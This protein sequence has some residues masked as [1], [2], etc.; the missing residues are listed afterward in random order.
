M[1]G[2]TLLESLIAIAIFAVIGL[3]AVD[4]VN[5][6]LQGNNKA[7]LI[8]KIKQNGQSAL[9]V[10]DETIRSA[11]SIDCVGSL[12]SLTSVISVAKN[13]QHT[14]FRLISQT[15]SSP[16]VNGV[17]I[18][19]NLNI[20]NQAI[21][22]DQNSKD[23]LCTILSNSQFSVPS[24]SNLTDIDTTSGAS[25][26]SGSFNRNQGYKDYISVMFNLG[27]AINAPQSADNQIGNILFQTT[28]SLR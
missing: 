7:Q 5:R 22:N 1:R 19:D 4:L 2:F 27:P 23:Q 17:I 3:I 15:A 8:S 24:F 10:M 21:L 12:D 18:Q 11:D 20:I 13:S 25:V 16:T 6:T 28:V 14:R 26:K 9:N